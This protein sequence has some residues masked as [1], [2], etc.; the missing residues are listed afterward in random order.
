MRKQLFARLTC[1]ASM[2]AL[3]V[4]PM[5]LA[6]AADAQ[7]SSKSTFEIPFVDVSAT[8]L[9]TLASPTIPGPGKY[10]NDHTVIKGKDGN[11][12]VIGI[13][14]GGNG[15][16]KSFYH[17][18][19]TQL[20]PP[21]V[22]EGG[23]GDY[24]N[25][26]AKGEAPAVAAYKDTKEQSC[27]AWAPSSIMKDGTAYLFFRSDRDQSGMCTRSSSRLEVLTSTDPTL[28]IWKSVNIYPAQDTPTF[29]VKVTGTPEGLLASDGTW[30]DPSPSKTG[31]PFDFRDPGILQNDDG[32]Y[33]LYS[34]AHDAVS[35]HSVVAVHKSSDLLNWTFAGTALKLGTGAVEAPWGST[36]SPFV[37]KRGD[38]YYLSTTVTGS[39]PGS[40][41]D[42]VVFRSKD[43][44]NFGTYGGEDR[45][46]QD[47]QLV[48]KLPLH[49]PEYVEDN[50]KTYVTTSGWENNS[51]YD[52]A[53]HG[54]AIAPLYWESALPTNG[55]QL[56][57]AF[58]DAIVS[59]SITDGS[60]KKNDGTIANAATSAVAGVTGNALSLAGGDYVKTPEIALTGDFTLAGW[61]K[62]NRN[63][64]NRD[65]LFHSK[66]G[67]DVNLYQ[68]L[69][70]LYVGGGAD[71]AT[72]AFPV[73]SGT[74]THIAVTRS[75][76]DIT[77][78]L[79]GLKAGAGRWE[80]VKTFTVDSVGKTVAGSLDGAL[81]DVRVYNRSLNS[82][83]VNNLV[84]ASAI[85]SGTK[86]TPL[87]ALNKA[88][89]MAGWVNITRTSPSNAD[90][91]FHGT[92]GMDLNFY[93]GYP[94]L[95]AGPDGDKAVSKTAVAAN[96]WTHIGVTRDSANVVTM[97]VNGVATGTGTWDKTFGLDAIGR[98]TAG[99]LQGSIAG[100]SVQTQARTADQIK[101]DAA[102]TNA[103][104]LLYVTQ[105]SLGTCGPDDTNGPCPQ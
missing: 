84:Q 61:I 22:K 20:Y 24:V 87:I 98:G 102:N 2:A 10:S 44:L 36:E 43:P 95:Y 93:Q 48:A 38:W 33:L 99:K 28:Q 45:P 54:V 11:W 92:G 71:V 18:I 89:T 75:N 79:N 51:I 90:G 39:D 12:H 41:H 55:L 40:Y 80:Q 52:Q 73:N 74:W 78:Y 7:Q 64:D 29:G 47:T 82:L 50:G 72:S 59:K 35:G 3:L 104:K 25:V 65:G 60:G 101:A 86:T 58:D 76:K 15:Y 16:E 26:T 4:A 105:N 19:L 69:P 21:V 62:V 23:T 83:E 5:G 6:C 46:S 32:S 88:F 49:A 53:K 13:T 37:F 81:D 68:S 91:L 57:Y 42:T 27:A 94:R 14:G 100:V 70:R 66:E 56:A 8:S 9:Q 31:W 97:Y 1:A 34:T 77:L 17:T 96:T 67:F 85:V 30:P 103:Q 63:P